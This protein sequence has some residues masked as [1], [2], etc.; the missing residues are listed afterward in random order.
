MSHYIFYFLTE[1]KDLVH[2][3][4]INYLQNL[5]QSRLNDNSKSLSDPYNVLHSFCLSLQ[6]E[7]LQAQA[8]RLIRERLGDL[9]K[10]EEY[11]P[12]RRLSLSYW[13]HQDDP[14]VDQNGD[15]RQPCKLT[16]EIDGQNISKPLQV[17]HVPDLTPDGV[18]F[19]NE[20][21]KSDYLSIE[22]LLIH[23]THERAKQELS[24]LQ[25]QLKG[26]HFDNSTLTGSPP[27]LQISVLDDSLP[28]EKLLLTVDPFNGHIQGYVPHFEDTPLIEELQAVLKKNVQKW[29]QFFEKLKVMIS[30]ERIRKTCELLPVCVL[31]RLPFL[32]PFDNEILQDPS[33][34]KLFIQF[35][36]HTKN[37][38]LVTISTS[39]DNKGT[40]K[41][42]FR[43]FMLTIHASP[44]ENLDN[45]PHYETDLPKV[46]AKLESLIELD[47]QSIIG[48][49]RL[50][51]MCSR[52]NT[53]V[54]VLGKRKIG[55]DEIGYKK[56]KLNGFFIPEIA[57]LV[58]FC[59]EKL[60]LGALS[61]ELQKRGICHHIRS[62][63]EPG[64]THYV[65]IIQYP[66]DN[67]GPPSKLRSNLTSCLIRLQ[68]KGTC[69]IWQVVL[70]FHSTPQLCHALRDTNIRKMVQLF[71]DYSSGSQAQIVQMVNDLYSDWTAISNLY[72]VVSEFVEQASL[73]NYLTSIEIKSFTY[74]RILIG[75]GPYKNF[76]LTIVWKSAEKRFGLQ[77]GLSGGT[78][79]NSNPHNIVSFQIQHEFNRHRSIGQLLQT[80]NN[81][82]SPLL[83]LQ[84]LTSIPILG[85]INNRLQIPLQSFCVVPQS[86]T[87]VRLIYREKFCLDILLTPDGFVAIRDG[88]F[89]LFDRAKAVENFNPI[90]G[91]KGFLGKF[92]DR[93]A[94]QMRRLSQTEDDNPPSPIPH[95][96]PNESCLYTQNPQAPSPI[97]NVQASSDPS[98][99]P[100]PGTPGQAIPSG[101]GMRNIRQ[102]L[103]SHPNTPASPH[104]S[105]L[106]QN[107]YA[108]S[109]NT[110]FPLA[111]PPSH[112]G[113]Q[114]PGSVGQIVLS[115]SIPN[116]GS[117][118]EQ[119]PAAM[120]GVNSPMN[121]MHAPSPSF[122]P[123]PS[124]SPQ[125]TNIHSPASNFMSS[126]QNLPSHDHPVNSP[127]PP[128][129]SNISMPSPASVPW[130]N[131]PSYK[132]SHVVQVNFINN[133]LTP[134]YLPHTTLGAS[135]P[136][137]SIAPPARWPKSW[138]SR[139]WY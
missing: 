43:Y 125:N 32:S 42:E 15:I 71:Y 101:P 105:V 89:S 8:L 124:P 1:G 70:T 7:V 25:E 36:R 114:G 66:P 113:Y 85:V 44:L 20:A 86:S 24:E 46:Y 75:Y 109:P 10:V 116:M 81:T 117:H 28:S 121:A 96:D 30:R 77:F 84:G 16:I 138:C 79:A 115:P 82:L 63:D 118:P 135:I 56:Q 69:K 55:D 41:P 27:V 26:M 57:F 29:P 2:P 131:S 119:S 62:G 14:R 13:R 45:H 132:V 4:Q 50:S 23:T 88:A 111:S 93:N 126:S 92:V 58:N 76:L 47:M 73:D 90:Q 123:I 129:G 102:N 99:L 37:H 6:L 61:A 103:V 67:F 53:N 38:L 9:I 83:T 110:S 87:H 122:L 107:N 130:P 22:K 94:T 139:T 80:L 39:A 136:I 100:A 127:Y 60:V 3:L 108:A 64:Y 21:I 128:V 31:E 12:G 95:M 74:K 52:K 68:G 51:G 33:T 72:D 54:S 19:A 40:Q 106:S 34:T 11:I 120:Y 134:F 35:S 59:E 78:I 48:S 112:G 133:Y 17:L 137:S 98:I 49:N 18:T 5:I 91:L 104:N 65:D 97:T